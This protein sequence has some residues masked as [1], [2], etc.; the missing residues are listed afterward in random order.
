MRKVQRIALVLAV[1]LMGCGYLRSLLPHRVPVEDDSSIKFPR[2]YERI[3]VAVGVQDEMYELDGEMLRALVIAF[4]DYL[5]TNAGDLPCA[6]RREAQSYRVIRQGRIIFVYI[7]E[8][9]VYCGRQYPV[10]H[11]GAKYAISTDGRVLRRLIGD[12]PEGPIELEAPDD[13]GR[14]IRAEPGVSSVFDYS[15]RRDGGTVPS[16]AQPPPA[17]DGGHDAG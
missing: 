7:H 12:Q 16:D 6:D 17:A 9:F 13:G 8:N 5:P 2:F 3:P 4:N 1:T 14:W 15:P 11:S 10:R